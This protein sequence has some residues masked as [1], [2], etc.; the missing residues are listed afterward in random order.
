LPPKDPAH[1][2]GAVLV[3]RHTQIECL[4]AVVQDLTDGQG[5]VLEVTGEPGIGKTTLLALLAE[6]AAGSGALV[7]RAH[8]ARGTTQPGQVIREVLDA[9]EVRDSPIARELGAGAGAEV[10]SVLGRWAARRGGVLV[11]DNVH[12]CDEQS[13]RLIAQLVRTVRPGAGAPPVAVQ[14]GTQRSA[15]TWSRD[16]LGHPSVPVLLGPPGGIHLARPQ[17]VSHRHHLP[18]RLLPLGA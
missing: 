15:R 13:A 11:L 7:A 4:S 2:S 5:T 10:R 9:L 18:A 16:R 17:G 1:E 6:R 12:L 3:G 14:P 8:A